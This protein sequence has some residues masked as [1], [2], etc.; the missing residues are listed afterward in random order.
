MITGSFQD[1]DSDTRT[2]AMAPKAQARPSQSNGG[3]VA[4]EPNPLV[5]GSRNPP[6]SSSATSA[7]EIGIA[8]IAFDPHRATLHQVSI[9]IWSQP[10]HLFGRKTHTCLRHLSS[11]RNI[12]GRYSC[13][14]Y[15]YIQ[16]KVWLGLIDW[17][18]QSGHPCH[19]ASQSLCCLLPVFR[20]LCVFSRQYV[21][22]YNGIV[23]RVC[24]QRHC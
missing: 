19:I 15:T 2:L 13:I 17:S 18:G 11:L 3:T 21:N 20:F 9:D 10:L 6:Q 16:R 5:H 4:G 7:S 1:P 14:F 24:T 8:R 12:N 22:V 23:Q